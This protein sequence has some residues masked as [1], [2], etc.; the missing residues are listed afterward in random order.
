MLLGRARG[1]RAV[2]RACDECRDIR[3]AAVEGR[4]IPGQR[5]IWDLL[6]AMRQPWLLQCSVMC[7]LQWSNMR[8]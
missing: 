1:D 8:L 2:R 6:R 4:H 7:E 3:L 5:H